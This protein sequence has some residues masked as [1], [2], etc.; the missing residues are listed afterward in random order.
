[1]LQI[2]V[3]D[4]SILCG[5]YSVCTINKFRKQYIF[6]LSPYKFFRIECTWNV[7]K[8]ATYFYFTFP[9]KHL[10]KSN[11]YNRQPYSTH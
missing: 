11:K 3:Q 8:S 10:S 9:Q 6:P 1:M 7:I 4:F 2:K 5:V